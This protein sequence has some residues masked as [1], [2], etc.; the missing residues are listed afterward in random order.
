VTYTRRTSEAAITDVC[1]CRWCLRS[2]TSL[3]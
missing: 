3:L 2:P 1:H